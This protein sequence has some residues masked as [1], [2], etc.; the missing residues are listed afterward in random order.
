MEKCFQK[1][2]QKEIKKKNLN[3]KEEERWFNIKKTLRVD[4]HNFV[5]TIN[6]KIIYA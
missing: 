5:V 4:A 1:K 6:K 3:L 2:V